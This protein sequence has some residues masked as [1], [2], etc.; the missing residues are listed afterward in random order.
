MLDWLITYSPKAIPLFT[1]FGIIISLLI[2]REMK[3][4]R[5]KSY[6]PILFMKNCNFFLQKNPNGSPSFLKESAEEVRDLYGPVS[7]IE[8]HN[9]GLGA[10]HTI[11]IQWRYDH[12]HLTDTFKDLGHK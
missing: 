11:K 1:F 7:H 12:K 5:E 9:I 6:E 8:L 3:I 4:Q 2:L 10:A